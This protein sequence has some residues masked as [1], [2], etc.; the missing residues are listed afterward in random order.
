MFTSWFSTNTDVTDL[1]HLQEA[2][3]DA[4]R[5]KDEFQCQAAMERGSHTPTP[6]Q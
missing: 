5:L 1:R 6:Y 4:G 3:E 2:L